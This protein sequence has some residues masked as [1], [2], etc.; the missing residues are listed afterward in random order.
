MVTSPLP[1]SSSRSL[2]FLKGYTSEHIIS[3]LEMQHE[4]VISSQSICIVAPQREDGTLPT[5]SLLLRSNRMS[6]FKRP[7]SDGRLPVSWLTERL[8]KPIIFWIFFD[9]TSAD[10]ESVGIVAPWF[11]TTSSEAI[12]FS[13]LDASLLSKWKSARQHESIK[14]I[15]AYH[16]NSHEDPVRNDDSTLLLAMVS[17]WQIGCK[18]TYWGCSY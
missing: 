9:E 11:L 15:D 12:I 5:N 14:S 13:K 8:K 4:Q 6:W 17:N 16:V 10:V 2:A 7:S 1:P 18:I 3:L